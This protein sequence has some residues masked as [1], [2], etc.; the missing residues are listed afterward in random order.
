MSDDKRLMIWDIRDKQPANSIE[1]HVAEIMSVDYSPFD[2]NLMITGSADR[3]VA[4][5]DTRNVKS[6]LFSLRQHKD[7]VKF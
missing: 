5:W 3:S 4:V 6:K 2:Q 1:A 7:E